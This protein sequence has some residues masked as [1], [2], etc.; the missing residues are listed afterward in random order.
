[1]DLS[2]FSL[3]TLS[4]AAGHRHVKSR[5]A[6]SQCL[7]TVMLTAERKGTVLFSMNVQGGQKKKQ[8]RNLICW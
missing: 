4:E 5:C 1:M 2:L 8:K 7:C 3:I 6:F